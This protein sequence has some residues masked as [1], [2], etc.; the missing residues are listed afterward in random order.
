MTLKFENPGYVYILSNESLKGLKIGYTQNC[1][2]DRSA[3]L[4]TTGVPTEFV[5]E[6]FFFVEDAP[7]CEELVH[8]RL[9]RHRISE[10]REF[11]RIE[12]DKAV[13]V[14]EQAID[15]L[16]ERLWSKNELKNTNT[17]TRSQ[18]INNSTTNVSNT[19]ESGT[20]P[21]LVNQYAYNNPKFKEMMKVL[22]ESKPMMTVEDIAKS[23][24]ISPAGVDKLITMMGKQQGVMLYTRE[25][26]RLI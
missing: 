21:P 20:P 9:T 10:S 5:V 7:L 22:K 1:P 24:K 15:D 16:R 12:L 2:Y 13:R 11:F 19:N 4:Y 25:V 23:I 6:K 18:S 17:N 8:N 26:C 14:V 3:D